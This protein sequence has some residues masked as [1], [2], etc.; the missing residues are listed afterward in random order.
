MSVL[1]SRLHFAI[2]C[3]ESLKQVCARVFIV[4]CYSGWSCMKSTI[5]SIN[6]NLLTWLLLMFHVCYLFSQQTCACPF[7]KSVTTR[8]FICYCLCAN[9]QY[10]ICD[11]SI[12][13]TCSFTW[14]PM[15]TN[16][17]HAWSRVL[18]QCC[19]FSCTCYM[20][21]HVKKVTCDHVCCYND[22]TRYFP[23]ASAW[24]VITYYNMF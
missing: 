21:S 2:A 19:T 3:V 7:A 17:C 18:W 5:F 13:L 14:N 16:F 23:C 10:F 15:W 6:V 1:W 9:L 12:L 20:L 22:F 11:N 24:Y 4:T 8:A